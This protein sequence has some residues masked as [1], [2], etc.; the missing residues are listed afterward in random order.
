MI[1]M[2][3][4][5]RFLPQLNAPYNIIVDKLNADGIASTIE[6]VKPEDV[7][8]SQG[9]V[10]SNEVQKASINDNHP[11]WIS[12]DNNLIDGHHRLIKAIY[13]DIPIK[14]I[15]VGLNFKDACRVLNK[16]QD[17]YDY[18]NHHE[19]EEVVNGEVINDFNSADSG[20][21]QTEFL[22]T[23]EEDNDI[24][25]SEKPNTKLAKTIVAYRKDKIKEN[26]V[27]GNFFLLEPVDG[28]TKYEIDFD[29]L[30][31]TNT[32][33]INYKEG[34]V[35]VDMLARSWFPNINFEELA[36]RYNT[37]AINL[38]SKAVS[39]KARKFGYDGIKYGNK[40][41]QGLG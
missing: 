27:V 12:N 29:N 40:I 17:I 13:D 7:Y 2:R 20:V 26:S 8:V 24:V 11:I 39:E 41:I 35:P 9:I 3:Y 38:K 18:E 31:D 5:P 34:Q 21:S 4:K 33:G 22:A 14:A 28:Y 10:F 30:L 6:E 1:D 15:R 37:D 19:I 32:F 23:L 16:I 36:K 25:L